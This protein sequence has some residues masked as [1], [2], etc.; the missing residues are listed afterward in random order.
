MVLPF[1]IAF[2]LPALLSLVMTPIVARLAVMIG[3]M[4]QPNE[5]KLHERA[6]PRLG[7]L[8]ILVGVLGS[9]SALYA[10]DST[11]FSSWVTR[12]EGL[13]LAASMAAMVGIGIW[14]DIWTLGPGRKYA[15]QL[16]VITL[17]YIAG[18]RIS[19]VTNPI[20]TGFLQLGIFDYLVT[21]LWIS[22][23]TNAINLIDGLDG[24]ASGVAMIAC[25]TIVPIA[26]MH[27]DMGSAIIAL[28]LAGALLGFLRYNFNPARIF[29]GDSGS[30]LVGFTLAVLSMRS[31]TKGSTVFA[32]VVPVLALGLPIM[33]T[34]LAMAR[35]LLKSFHPKHA[36][37]QSILS[38]ITSMFRPDRSH[39]HHRLL[40][41][42]LSHR[43]AVL[44]LYVVSCLFGVVAFAVTV[45]N[46]AE[47]S[48]ILVVVAAAA[49]I[50]VR[51]LRYKE[52]HVL[53]NGL[54]LP[55]Y[56]GG[57]INR[58]MFLG[59][60]DLGFIVLACFIADYVTNWDLLTQPI[61]RDQVLRV[62]LE[63]TI[64]FTCLWAFGLYKGTV[65]Q[66]GVADALRI[67][68][69]VA[70]AIVMTGAAFAFLLRPPM[71]LPVATLIVNFYLLLS[72][73]LGFRASFRLLKHFARPD[74]DGSKR[75]L[76][77][78]VGFNATLVLEKILHGDIPNLVPVGFLDDDPNLEG[79][80]INGYPVL[81]GH[82]KLQ[83]L[84]NTID[85]DEILIVTE[86]IKP[87][88]Q[89]RLSHLAHT[90]GIRLRRL[91]LSLEQ[92]TTGRPA[93]QHLEQNLLDKK[94]SI[95]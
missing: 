32:I 31:S 10:W 27:A 42:G 90:T 73:I 87:E 86:N 84:L 12:K 22:G 54:F 24:L 95:T 67:V 30:L 50:G 58:D 79:K 51:Q 83:R 18:F 2:V 38:R 33:D 43:G 81:G 45:L 59:F 34:L 1:A 35:R 6:I 60:L 61:S 72:F 57:L 53:R 70:L 68:K 94:I 39:I 55:M 77:Y 3:A 4:D 13:V 11:L 74:E 48:L 62:A 44:V 9:L 89:K 80:H 63:C 19:S 93:P 56:Q 52:M 40:A 85:I 75:V 92:L 66:V 76:I 29:L 78:G 36:G 88:V 23:V 20:G 47:V 65:R 7:G 69:A 71:P 21:V 91:S 14:D 16:I 41:R 46:H 49:I 64:Q 17:L 8:A 37:T 26:F 5:R 25:L 82:W 15:L 28:V